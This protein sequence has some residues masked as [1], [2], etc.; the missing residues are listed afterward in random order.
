MNADELSTLLEAK[1]EEAMEMLM[2]L[3]EIEPSDSEWLGYS[4]DSLDKAI[5]FLHNYQ[6]EK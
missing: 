6:D 5:T 3:R 2:K 1:L 4:E